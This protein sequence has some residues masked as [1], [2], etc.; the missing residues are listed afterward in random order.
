LNHFL[1]GINGIDKKRRRAAALQ[2]AAATFNVTNSA[3]RFGLRQP[4]GAFDR[5]VFIANDFHFRFQIN[6]AFSFGPLF[7]SGNQ[8]Q[9]I[10]GRGQT[11]VHDE[12]AMF[13]GHHRTANSRAFQAQFIHQ[14]PGGN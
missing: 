1:D 14:F 12:I 9:N 5:L 13:G 10:A 8:V 2:D 4:S 7:K 11:I 3:S 6:S